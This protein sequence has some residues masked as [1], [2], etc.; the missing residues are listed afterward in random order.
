MSALVEAAPPRRPRACSACHRTGHDRR[1]C[2]ERPPSPS[3]PRAPSLDDVVREG[4]RWA[5]ASAF[6]GYLPELAAALGLEHEAP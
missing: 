2:P 5:I 4:V 1:R 3:E 6:R